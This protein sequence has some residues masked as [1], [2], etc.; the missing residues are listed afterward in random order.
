MTYLL[1]GIGAIT[2]LAMA[3]II[4]RALWEERKKPAA[5]LAGLAGALAAGRSLVELR[6]AGK[7]A[8][9]AAGLYCHRVRRGRRHP[10]EL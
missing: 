10:A 9:R 6:R 2:A 5:A 1:C 8:G 4:G 3:G 7:T